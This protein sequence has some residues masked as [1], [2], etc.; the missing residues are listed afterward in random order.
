VLDLQCQVIEQAQQGDGPA[1]QCA[2]D[3]ETEEAENPASGPAGHVT[4]QPLGQDCSTLRLDHE[5]LVEIVE[6][7]CKRILGQ[8]NAIPRRGRHRKEEEIF[9]EEGYERLEQLVSFQFFTH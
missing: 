7:A 9:Q 6:A 3:E 2:P 1:R 4:E 8:G 5:E